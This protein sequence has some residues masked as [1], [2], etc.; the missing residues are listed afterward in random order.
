MHP[1]YANPDS[2]KYYGTYVVL[3]EPVSP[4]NIVTLFFAI[5]SIIS[6]LYWY[7]GNCYFY[8]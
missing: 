8:N 1:F 2:Y 5:L 7:I 6:Y 4:T 3:P